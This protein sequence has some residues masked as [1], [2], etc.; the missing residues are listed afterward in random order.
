MTKYSKI[1]LDI[2]SSSDE[3]LTAEQIYM[4]TKSQSC[5]A[6]MATVYNNL[7]LLVREGLIRKINVDNSPDRYD[8][9]IRHDHLVCKLCGKISDLYLEDLTSKFESDC[10]V[11]FESYDLKLIYICEKCKTDNM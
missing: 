3:H 11:E 6:V 1:I 10:S 2:I 7:N 4:R 9:I 5:K 8:K